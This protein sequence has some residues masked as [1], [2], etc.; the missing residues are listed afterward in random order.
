MPDPKQK[1]VKVDN[2]VISFPSTMGDKDIS[3]AIKKHRSK[4]P[5]ATEE[6]EHARQLH[7][8]NPLS[9][10]IPHLPIWTQTPLLPYAERAVTAVD[11]ATNP[12][13]WTAE[14]RKVKAKQDADQAHNLA[15]FDKDHPTQA[16]I[17]EGIRGFGESMSTPVNMGLMVAMPESKVLSAFFALQ[18]ATGAYRDTQDARQAYHEGRNKDAARLATQAVLGAGMAG[19]A[20]THAVKG[21]PLGDA[22]ASDAR[23]LAKGG[24]PSEG[25]FV[26]NP[27]APRQ[28]VV[29]IEQPKPSI[30]VSANFPPLKEDGPKWEK[31]S[32]NKEIADQFTRL[33]ISGF[34]ID[35]PYHF[36]LSEQGNIDPTT[37]KIQISAAASDPEH[38]LSH[39]L[40]HDIY[41]RLSPEVKQLVEGYVKNSPAYGAHAGGIEERVAD[42]FADVILG[43][44]QAP[45]TIKKAFF[46]S[47]LGPRQ[48]PK[49]LP[50]QVEPPEPQRNPYTQS[51]SEVAK[52][53]GGNLKQG[54]DIEGMVQ[55]DGDFPL[56]VKDI[57]GARHVVPASIVAKILK[58]PLVDGY[59]DS[60]FMAKDH[61]AEEGTN[62]LQ[63]DIK[64]YGEMVAAKRFL[65]TDKTPEGKY[66]STPTG[67]QMND[68]QVEEWT[69]KISTLQNEVQKRESPEYKYRPVPTYDLDKIRI[70]H[71]G[72]RPLIR[73]LETADNARRLESGNQQSL[74]PSQGTSAM[75][76][77]VTEQ[78]NKS[79]PLKDIMSEANIRNPNNQFRIKTPDGSTHVFPTQD[80]LDR[81]ILEAGLK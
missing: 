22:I 23:T 18:S 40:S 43:R 25:G 65:K 10:A 36:G 75:L 13:N 69:R 59:V 20:G 46:E 4:F 12:L 55:K 76:S 80:A 14:G 17:A 9:T 38:T 61:M 7:P 78:D 24:R 2:D 32:K 48:E 68:A 52:Y 28:P 51:W 64:S 1:L 42:H 34:S 30:S 73:A 74:S 70:T 60:V 31:A 71:G 19:M 27:L 79:L 8:A 66:V 15:A 58:D 35:A 49:K 21:T 33:G 54:D 56:V 53:G 81:F 72:A 37:G 62:K 3:A 41:N 57:T 11:N 26:E 6:S 47:P 39:E 50:A 29:S 16:G 45:V 44:D 5:V 63:N 77:Q 67:P